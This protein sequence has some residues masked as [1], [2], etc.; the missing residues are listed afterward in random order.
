[1]TATCFVARPA[2]DDALI[3]ALIDALVEALVEGE[4]S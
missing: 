3:D 2:L 4:P 1:M